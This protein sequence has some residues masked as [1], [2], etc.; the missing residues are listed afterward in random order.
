M[1]SLKALDDGKT[2]SID[3]RMFLIGRLSRCHLRSLDRR[4]SRLHCLVTLEDSRAYLRDLGSTTGTLLNDER[5]DQEVELHHG[6]R[7][8]IGSLRFEVGA[9]SVPA[10]G[11]S[12]GSKNGSTATPLRAEMPVRCSEPRAIGTSTKA[13][14]ASSRRGTAN[15]RPAPR[16]GRVPR[17]WFL[18]VSAAA[19][20]LAVVGLFLAVNPKARLGSGRSKARPVTG[21]VKLDQAPLGQALILFIPKPGTPSRGASGVTRPD[22]SFELTTAEGREITPGQ[23]TVVISKST[24]T[25]AR[26]QSDAPSAKSAGGEILHPNYSDPQKSILTATVPEGGGEID[27]FLTKTGKKTS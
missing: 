15:Q 10:S 17:H 12:A 21:T 26:L 13:A 18:G 1:L 24:R 14:P 25:G 19:V 5:I 9:G 23:Y 3:R 7:I 22:G 4:I 6:D 11:A 2:I 20:V 8:Q 16:Q 27:F